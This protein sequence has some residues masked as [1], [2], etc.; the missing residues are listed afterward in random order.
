[1]G[2]GT[3]S[4][5]RCREALPP[6]SLGHHATA[7]ATT[8]SGAPL[9][10]PPP[11]AAPLS[12]AVGCKGG[13]RACLTECRSAA[14]PITD[15]ASLQNENRDHSRAFALWHSGFGLGCVCVCVCVFGI[16]LSVNFSCIYEGEL[17]GC[18]IRCENWT[19]KRLFT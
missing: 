7:K 10:V 11:G 4:H 12:K 15:K 1:M 14:P 13:R 8:G 2:D 16:F 5:W 19:K 3:T 6:P 17:E 18:K 9:L